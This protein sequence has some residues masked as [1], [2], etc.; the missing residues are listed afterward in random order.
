MYNLGMDYNEAKVEV[1]KLV[2]EVLKGGTSDVLNHRDISA[3]TGLSATEVITIIVHTF[4]E[5]DDKDTQMRISSKGVSFNL[6]AD[7]GM[8]E[9]LEEILEGLDRRDNLPDWS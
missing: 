9:R 2:L 5:M 7:A 3:R 1:L 6:E 4:A 8:I